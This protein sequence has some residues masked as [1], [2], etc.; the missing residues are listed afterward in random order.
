MDPEPQGAHILTASQTLNKKTHCLMLYG[1]NQHN[2]IKQLFSNQNIL[3][4]HNVMIN[5][6]KNK[7]TLTHTH[8]LQ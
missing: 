3:K 7:K 6:K 1:R 2:I 5:S 4:I 8:K